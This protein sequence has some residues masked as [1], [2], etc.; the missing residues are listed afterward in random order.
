MAGGVDEE[1]NGFLYKGDWEIPGNLFL[2]SL[3]E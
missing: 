1:D 3:E 2:L